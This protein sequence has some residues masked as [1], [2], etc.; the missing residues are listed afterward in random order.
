MTNTLWRCEQVRAGQ[1]WNKMMFDTREEAED[2]VSQ[3]RK[4]E[5]DIF[6]RLEAV[7]AQMVWN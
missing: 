1:V 6:W 7:A 3:M 4:V 5:P 2:F